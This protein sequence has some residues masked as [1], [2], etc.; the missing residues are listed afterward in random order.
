MLMFAIALVVEPVL[1]RHPVVDH[2]RR[3]LRLRPIAITNVT[4]H[5]GAHRSMVPIW[6]ILPGVQDTRLSFRVSVLAT[7]SHPSNRDSA[8]GRTGGLRRP[9]FEVVDEAIH[10]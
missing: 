5:A 6:C 8:R 3:G 7:L 2:R 1:Q 10:R 4:L 9:P